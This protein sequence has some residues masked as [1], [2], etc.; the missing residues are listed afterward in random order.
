MT[1]VTKI[2]KR[3]VKKADDGRSK[4]TERKVE[5]PAA[6]RTAWTGLSQ[7]ELSRDGG[8]LLAWLIQ[9]ANERGMQMKE[10]ASE[11]DVT[12]GYISQLRNGTRQM[13][14]ISD[15]FAEAAARFLGAPRIAIY[16]AAGRIRPEDVLE[17]TD[18]RQSKLESALHFIQKDSAW[19]PML[20]PSV[21]K[22]DIALQ[23]FVVFAFEQ[24]TD[25]TLV[26]GKVD[27][28]ELAKS[29]QA[30]EQQVS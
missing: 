1:T 29:I 13:R 15:E 23:Q 4:R 30:L 7:E 11:L 21:F 3:N 6:R 26:P 20:P 17:S 9:A 22:A 10:L 12:Y 2:N 27:V 16:M 14:H 5:K 25:T 8:V 18:D 19:G 28:K 24:A